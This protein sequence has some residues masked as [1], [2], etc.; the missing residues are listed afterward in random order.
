MLILWVLQAASFDIFDYLCG[1]GAD[2]DSA[3]TAGYLQRLRFK[4]TV[5]AVRPF[6]KLLV[7]RPLAFGVKTD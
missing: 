6:S 4:A 3:A 5:V 2:S 1:V 7:S